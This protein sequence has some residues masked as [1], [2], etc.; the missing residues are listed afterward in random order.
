MQCPGLGA[1]V[2]YHWNLQRLG[3][4]EGHAHGEKPEKRP[5][6]GDS[7]GDAAIERWQRL[8]AAVEEAKRLVGAWKGI[9]EGL[10]GCGLSAMRI[11]RQPR[12]RCSSSWRPFPARPQYKEVPIMLSMKAIHR[13]VERLENNDVL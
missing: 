8:E 1:F 5:H 13:V 2:H 3:S 9:V 10:G 11:A 6:G 7:A 4:P 12:K